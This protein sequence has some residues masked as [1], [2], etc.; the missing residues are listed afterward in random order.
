MS[1]FEALDV[2][3]YHV[4]AAILTITDSDRWTIANMFT[5][6]VVVSYDY[7]LVWSI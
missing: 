2:Y 6:V 7:V 4:N 5:L 3:P 1:T